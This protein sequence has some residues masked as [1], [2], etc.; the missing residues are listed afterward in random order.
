[1]AF[2]QWM[3]LRLFCHSF[4]LCTMR[5]EQNQS[6]NMFHFRMCHP[7]QKEGEVLVDTFIQQGIGLD[8]GLYANCNLP[9]PSRCKVLFHELEKQVSWESSLPC[10][11]FFL[12][13]A[14]SGKISG[15]AVTSRVYS[16]IQLGHL[17]IVTHQEKCICY[18][19]GNDFLLM[20][21]IRANLPTVHTSGFSWNLFGRNNWFLL[22]SYNYYQ[23]RFLFIFN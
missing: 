20:H 21:I 3:L 4:T 5:Q 12:I 18:R 13:P 6:R 15:L 22:I 8:Y 2:L 11:L 14:G 17:L 16:L 10:C 23:K 9:T 19:T 1:M 7:H